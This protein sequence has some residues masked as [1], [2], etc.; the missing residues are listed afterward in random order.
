MKSLINDIINYVPV[1]EKEIQEKEM[2]LDF[3]AKNPNCLTRE[4]KIAHLTV[5]SWVVNPQRTKVI[6]AYHNIYD[7]WAWL[8]GHADGCSDL[9]EVALKEAREEA[10]LKDVRLV[11]RDILSLEV[12]TV[13]GHVKKGNWVPC[14]LHLNLTYLLEAPEE[15]D[16]TVNEEENSGVAWFTFEEAL[17]ASR[18]PWFVEHIYS[19]LI[20]KM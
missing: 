7:S 9:P 18:E 8:G 12:L 17:K 13:D 2:I 11:S 16:L 14:H 19:K 5:S 1:G 15:T 10:G 20:A 6:M 4:N 3:I